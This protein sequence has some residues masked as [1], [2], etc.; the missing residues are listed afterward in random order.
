MRKFTLIELLVVIAIIGVLVTILMPSLRKARETAKFAVCKSNLAQQAKLVMIASKDNNNRLPYFDNSGWNHNPKNPQIDRHSWHGVTRTRGSVRVVNPVR[1]LYTGNKTDFWDNR[2]TLR[3]G[4][5]FTGA[6]P[7]FESMKCPS[8][9]VGEVFSGVGSNGITDYSFAAAFSMAYIDTISTE[10][11]L[12]SNT[13]TR[14]PVWSSGKSIITPLV[15]GEEVGPSGWLGGI[16]G[17]NIES[18]WCTSDTLTRRHML[19]RQMGSYAA[20]DGSISTYSD[21]T[22]SPPESNNQ[23]GASREAGRIMVDFDGDYYMVM[24]NPWV[25]NNNLDNAVWHKRRTNNRWS[26]LKQ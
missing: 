7:G 25:P 12:D 24:R 5:K 11:R 17:G 1:F 9:A 14:D 21:R 4:D 15:V 16:N 6:R 13:R 3:A 10:A 20:I 19:E 23:T 22:Y 8:L 26:K 18:G 2:A